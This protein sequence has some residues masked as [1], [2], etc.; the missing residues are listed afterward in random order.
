V[1]VARLGIP[2]QAIG[3]FLGS[4]AMDLDVGSYPRWDDL[5][6]YM[7]GSAAVIGEMMLPVLEPLDQAA[8]F[9]PAR[10]LGLAFQLT[11]FLRDVGEDLERG[12]VYL[13][14]E[15]LA[16]F[17]ADPWIRTVTPEWRE[18]IRFE[19]ARARA[20]YA[21]ADQGLPW[22]PPRSAACVRAARILYSRILVEIE[23]NDYDVFSTRA[24]VSI[25][26]KLATAARCLG[27]TI[28]TRKP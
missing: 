19:I 24:R 15:D 11:N 23:G 22:L 10:D 27:G 4:M 1:T 16:R 17:G 21:S 12:R 14:E 25:G 20:L 3:R 9:Q 7:D 28:G 18:L 8:A 13:P 6:G 26:R 2:V 5:L